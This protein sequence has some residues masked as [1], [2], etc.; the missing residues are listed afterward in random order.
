MVR[1]IKLQVS[2]LGLSPA[3]NATLLS[4][5]K[6]QASS[7]RLKQQAVP[8]LPVGPAATQASNSGRQ[9][10]LFQA[11][12]LHNSYVF[13]HSYCQ[14]LDLTAVPLCSK[15]STLGFTSLIH[16]LSTTAKWGGLSP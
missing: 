7:D 9:K 5:Q 4:L 10:W 11:C 12:R 1:L 8:T 15:S 14:C 2:S 3:L 16:S 13:H 6:H